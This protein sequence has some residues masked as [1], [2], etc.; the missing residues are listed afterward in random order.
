MLHIYDL[1]FTWNLVHNPFIFTV[2]TIIVKTY[3]YPHGLTFTD[4]NI[5]TKHQE[6]IDYSSCNIFVSWI[7][8]LS[9]KI[10]IGNM[11]WTACLFKFWYPCR[12]RTMLMWRLGIVCTISSSSNSTIYILYIV[13]SCVFVC[14][15]NTCCY[16]NG[17]T[18]WTEIFRKDN[19]HKTNP[20]PDSKVIGCSMFVC[21][22]RTQKQLN[23]LSWYFV[24]IFPW[25]L[26]WFLV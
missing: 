6:I 20:Y 9:F 14:L 23:R 17:W 1:C 4:A 19:R 13:S 12:P 16:R 18:D 22:L 26:T 7:F 10:F 3:Y 25:V 2:R 11:C 24:G 5:L 21:N 15:F 8:K